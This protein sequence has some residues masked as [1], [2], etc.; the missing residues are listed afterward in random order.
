VGNTSVTET[1]EQRYSCRAYTGQPV[2]QK[3]LE[4]LL[5]KAGMSPSGANVQPWQV[6][7][8]GPKKRD[9]LTNVINKKVAENNALK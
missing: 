5:L 9:E 4:Q 3:V 1:L 2:T 6:H 7:V 8:L